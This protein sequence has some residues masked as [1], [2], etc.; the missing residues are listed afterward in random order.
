[1]KSKIIGEVQFPGDKS[2]SHRSALFSALYSGES[3]FTNFNYNADCT[4]TLHCLKALGIGWKAE[5]NKL[6]VWG[7][8]PQ[9]WRAAGS[10][11]DAGN[12][13]TTARL[14]SGLL[15]GLS[16][17]NTLLGDA[18]LSKRPMKRVI[19][20][21]ASMGARIESHNT[22]LPLTYYP[23]PELHGIY[24]D[25]P[26]A[27]AQVKSAVLL[28]G[29]LAEGKTTV[30][31]NAITRDHTERLLGLP[32]KQG[33]QNAFREIESSK[34][35]Q[36]PNISMEI[37]GDI[38]SAAFFITAAAMMPGSELRVKNVSLNPTRSGILTAL[39]KMGAKI[40]THTKASEPE[41][42]GDIHIRYTPLQNLHLNG[43][44]IPNIIDEIP[45]L[46]ILATRSDGL[47]E[48]SDAEELRHKE[49]DRISV[50]VKNLRAIGVEVQQK[51]DG[52][53]IKG[54]QKINGGKVQTRGDHRIAMSFGIARLLSSDTIE[55]DQPECADVSFP[56]FWKTL[57]RLSEH[58]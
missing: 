27:S 43:S 8:H 17:K 1:L 9:N 55:I 4:A 49:S 50:M 15:C 33:R 30:K 22:R 41:P 37:P 45:I 10:A 12:S 19:D 56:G 18:S 7:K 13:G 46:C 14:I 40:E 29:L 42:I 31:E 36:I 57:E 3:V 25:L 51:P 23:V 32:V 34:E 26:M 38:S 48:I 11:L 53:I 54:P 35:I 52:M 16:V 58:S 20:P 21:L 2:I 44:I 39:Q 47:F 5:Q 28:A 24:Y 6:V